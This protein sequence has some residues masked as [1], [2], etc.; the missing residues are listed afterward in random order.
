MSYILKPQPSLAE[1]FACELG[2]QWEVDMLSLRVVF[3]HH[4]HGVIYSVDRYTVMQPGP[5]MA[6][7]KGALDLLETFEP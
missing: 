3:I 2:L 5:W 1:M 7:L 4:R 6:E